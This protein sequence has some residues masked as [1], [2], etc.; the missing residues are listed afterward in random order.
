MLPKFGEVL[1]MCKGVAGQRRDDCVAVGR[2][3]EADQ[4]GSILSRMI[5]SAMLRRLFKGTPEEVAAKELRREYVWMGEQMESNPKPNLELLQDETV[6]FGEWEALAR[7][8]ERMGATR[9]PPAG[10]IPKNPQTLL[11]SE[12]R[13]PVPSK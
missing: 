8:T 3:L 2:L 11:L 6:R 10:W 4:S 13:T 12:E 5:G 9:L 7:F 1:K